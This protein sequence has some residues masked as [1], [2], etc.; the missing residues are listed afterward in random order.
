M[1]EEKT[2]QQRHDE[3]QEGVKPGQV[4]LHNKFHPTG[5]MKG[6]AHYVN[7]IP[8]EYEIIEK[9][10][11]SDAK[12]KSRKRWRPVGKNHILIRPIS[13]GEDKR[14]ILPIVFN[15][16]T[17]SSRVQAIDITKYEFWIARNFIRRGPNSWSQKK[18]RW[19]MQQV[20]EFCIARAVSGNNNW[21]NPFVWPH[22]MK[23]PYK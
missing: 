15:D 18:D 14:T 13:I 11:N 5:W 2:N 3:L 17:L 8:F 20:F 6:F 23:D 9:G 4:R 22:C 21:E 10:Q 16:H 19:I 1:K 7:H 12:F